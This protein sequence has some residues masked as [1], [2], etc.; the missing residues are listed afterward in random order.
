MENKPQI[1]F[2]I[3]FTPGIVMHLRLFIM[4]LLDHSSCLFRIIANGCSKEEE[5]LLKEFC[6]IDTRLEYYKLP[7]NRMVEHS[8]VIT[9]LLSAEKSEYFCFMDPDIVA[10]GDFM[11]PF[12]PLL[13]SHT[14]IFSG[15]AIWL[16]TEGQIL[17]EKE[18]VMGGRFNLTENGFCLGSTFFAI[19][20]YEILNKYLQHSPITFDKYNSW[21]RIPPECQSRLENVHLRMKRYDTGKVL[22][23]LMQLDGNKFIFKE[24]PHLYH[25]GGL[26][27]LL[28]GPLSKV[29]QRGLIRGLN[30]ISSRK[31]LKKMIT[32]RT[33]MET[34]Y[35]R[36]DAADYFTYLLKALF[37]GKKRPKIF[38]VDDKKISGDIQTASNLIVEL[39]DKYGHLLIT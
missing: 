16:N 38:R 23:I 29:R 22:N 36:R 4:S 15:T 27:S 21:E 30:K 10:S 35:I 18:K 5:K 32:R 26:S 31:Y 14:G 37:E 25:I 28:V 24:S 1:K 12:Y 7:I 17:P 34:K 33:R 6:E 19:Y 39:Y 20:H 9:H 11:A 13:E 2:N 8:Q 3:I